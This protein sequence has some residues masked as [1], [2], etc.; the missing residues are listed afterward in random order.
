V[1]TAEDFAGIGSSDA[2]PWEVTGDPKLPRGERKFSVSTSD[3][4]FYFRTTNASGGAMFATPASGT[5]SRTQ[6]RNSL[7]YNPGFQNWNL[8]VFKDFTLRENQRIQFRSEFFNWPNHPNWGGAD[9]NPRS[10]RSAK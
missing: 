3:S 6:T 1:A 7:L 5:F 4:N 8:A 9:A 10:G 2:Q